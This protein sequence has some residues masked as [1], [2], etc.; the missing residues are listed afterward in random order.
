MF[1]SIFKDFLKLIVV[2]GVLWAGF[3]FFSRYK[4]T[5]LKKEASIISIE[6]E[7]KIGKLLI[8]N[9]LLKNP[10]V[11]LVKNDTVDSAVAIISKRL[12]DAIGETDYKY[13]IKV[14]D[15]PQINAFTM[16][17]GNIFIY[18]GLLTE[19][20]SAEEVASVLAH[21]IGHAEKRHLVSRMIKE[22]GITIVFSV[23]T[24]GDAVLLNEITKTITSTVFDRSQEKEADEFALK[25]MEDARI[26]PRILASFFRKVEKHTGK[27]DNYSE[28]ISTHPSNDTRIKAAL[29]YSLSKDFVEEPFELNW[30][31][32]KSQLQ[33]SSEDL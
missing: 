15:D 23:L 33:T 24:G 26:N 11:K 5:P 18:S 30:T 3:Y 27:M 28:I 12:I 10:S 2:A 4:E 9:L 32:V 25:L 14:I 6:Q 13:T 7:E 31:N 20:E 29:E 22:L 19:A 16:P 8:D 17:G 1:N 21:E